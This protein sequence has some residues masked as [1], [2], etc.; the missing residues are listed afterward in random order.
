MKCNAGGESVRELGRFARAFLESRGAAVEARDETSEA[1]LPESLARLLD[2]PEYVTLAEGTPSQGQH[3]ESGR[4]YLHFGS[5]VL[6]KM[7]AALCDECPLI[8][9]RTEVDYLKSQGF[10]R[11]IKESFSFDKAVGA[12]KNTAEILTP[13]ICVTCRYQAQSDEQKEGLV[14]LTFNRDTGALVTAMEKLLAVTPKQFFRPRAAGIQDISAGTVTDWIRASIGDLIREELAP[15]QE[16][17]TRRFRRDMGNLIDYYSALHDEMEKSL[18]RPGLSTN[19]VAER[20]EKM[21]LLI[22]ELGRKGEDLFKKYSIRVAVTPCTV[23]V[24]RTRA[25]KVLYELARGKRTAAVS[26][27]YNPVTK[28]LDPLV[29][30]KCR[31]SMTTVY[32]DDV[33]RLLCLQCAP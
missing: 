8:E 25:V 32:F 31:R 7:T 11:L 30:R 23:M 18:Q 19:L 27:I 14:S 9:C 1:V 13:Y 29:C 4:Y 20:K 28:E 17:M 12:V 24:I 15:F 26:F 2:L 33:M 6:E 3:R 21:A 16:S 10:D 5:P 22:E